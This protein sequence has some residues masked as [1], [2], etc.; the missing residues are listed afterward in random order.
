MKRNIITIVTVLMML[1]MTG[2]V[3]KIDHALPDNPIEFNTSSFRDPVS[4]DEYVAIEY[5]GR[6][7]IPFG[8]LT[9]SLD[10]GDVGECLGYLIQDGQRLE[11]VRLFTLVSDADAN[12]IMEIDTGGEMSQPD[13]YRAVDTVGK[14]ITTPP[15][16][17]SLGYE[18]W[19]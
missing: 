15:F 17:E 14:D 5:E 7:Y 4:K 13:F 6:T 18:Y 2:C 19:K 3:N 1:L 11:N 10:N 12:Y 16:I 9:G 8:T